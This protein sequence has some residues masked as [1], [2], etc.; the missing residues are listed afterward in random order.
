MP[1]VWIVTL[2]IFEFGFLALTLQ[3]GTTAL[4]EG[5]RKGAELYPPTFPFD[6]AGDDNDI[7]DQIVQCMNMHLE[8]QCLEIP[9]PLNGIPDDPAH[10]NALVIIERGDGMGGFDTV[11]RGSLPGGM[12]CTPGGPAP[13]DDEIRVTLCFALVDATNPDGCGDPVPDWLSKFGFSLAECHFEMSARA[14]LE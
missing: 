10:A 8:V 11:T 2:A 5:T 1:L 13:D 9:D 7:A 14:N 12:V 4:I 3:T 6:L